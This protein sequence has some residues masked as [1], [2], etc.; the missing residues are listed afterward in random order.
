MLIFAKTK[1]NY[2]EQEFWKLTLR[3]YIALRDIF[4]EENKALEDKEI[5][6]DD[7]L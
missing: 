7:F 1:L 2:T 6:A 3:K 5:F 4:F